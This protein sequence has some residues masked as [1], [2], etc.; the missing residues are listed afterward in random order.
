MLFP[1]K[2]RCT[3]C[4]QLKPC[5]TEYFYK[6][7]KS[8]WGF[9]AQ[10]KECRHKY[11]KQQYEENKEQELALNKE[12]REKNKDKTKERYKKWREEH[13]EEIKEYMQD[14]NK[15]Y[16]QT[17]RGK[18][19]H[20]KSN[21][22]RRCLMREQTY[23]N[24]QL[25]ECLIFFNNCCAYSGKELTENYSIDHIIA[26]SKNGE[27]LIWNLVPMDKDLNSSKRDKDM[28]EWYVQQDFYSKERLNKIYEWI[29]Y[30]KNKWNNN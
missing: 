20:N 18:I 26:L 17:E 9:K 25:E 1:R 30:A 12:Y 13:K 16:R 2:K 3:D 14:Y 24:E 8:K 23:T 19:N 10:C 29:E 21:H 7:K 4:K 15:E 22:K 5:T 11:R 6:N 28:L 27:N